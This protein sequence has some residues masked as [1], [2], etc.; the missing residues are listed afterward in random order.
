VSGVLLIL[1]GAL[2]VAGLFQPFV[3][4]LNARLVG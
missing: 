2:L 4:W 3:F 1:M